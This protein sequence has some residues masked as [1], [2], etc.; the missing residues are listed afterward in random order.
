MI[1]DIPLPVTSDATDSAFWQA[2]LNGEL[3]VQSCSTCGKL[4][5]PPR[6]M[7]PVCQSIEQ[8][9]IKLSGHGRIWSFTVPS[10]PLLPAFEALLPYVVAL[11]EVEEDPCIRIVGPVLQGETG[12]MKG[13]DAKQLKIGQAVR[14]EF[15][16]YADD[17]ALPCWITT[18]T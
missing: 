1:K 6:P 2:T 17:V 14:V 16:K 11:V 4:R 9:W 5:F 18:E 10:P 12:E 8:N 7:C 13:V 3:R 15:K